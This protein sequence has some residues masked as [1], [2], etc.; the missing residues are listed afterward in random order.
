MKFLR[1]LKFR[2]YKVLNQTHNKYADIK[3]ALNKV[4]MIAYVKKGKS[5]T[6]IYISEK[7][8]RLIKKVS[9]LILVVSILI[10]FLALPYVYSIVVSLAI[11]LIEQILERVAFYYVSVYIVPFPSWEIWKKA[12]FKAMIFGASTGDSKSPM[13]VGMAFGDEPAARKVWKYIESWSADPNNDTDDDLK[14][15]LVINRK[16]HS[17]AFFAYPSFD[18][19]SA[20]EFR[21]KIESLEKNK[22]MDH[23]THQAQMILIKVFPLRENSSLNKIFLPNYKVGTPFIFKPFIY[24]ENNTSPISGIRGIYK[25]DIK[26]KDISELTSKDIEYHHSKHRI[27]WH[28]DDSDIPES[29]FMEGTPFK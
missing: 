24:T 19:K 15:S 8:K 10:S 21:S 2:I 18:R 14:L 28:Q 5:G 22:D 9:R 29:F 17:Y 13:L 27:N 1:P 25:K 20:Q 4:R 12:D 7:R 6:T 23:I 26:V 3:I 16:A 11:I